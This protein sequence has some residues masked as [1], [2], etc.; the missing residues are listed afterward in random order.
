MPVAS[1]RGCA[2]P[3]AADGRTH[4]VVASELLTLCERRL[5]VADAS[6]PLPENG[7]LLDFLDAKTDWLTSPQA[8]ARTFQR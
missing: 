1:H 5:G 8:A 4:A 2:I 3:L 6:K 7:P